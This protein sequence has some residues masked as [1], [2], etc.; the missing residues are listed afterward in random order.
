MTMSRDYGGGGGGGALERETEP[1]FRFKSGSGPFFS[2]PV[3]TVGS[4]M[5]SKTLQSFPV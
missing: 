5:G 4:G 3:W 2:G 1:W